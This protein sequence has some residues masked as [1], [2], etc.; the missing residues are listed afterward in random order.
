MDPTLFTVCCRTEK[1][2]QCCQT[3]PQYGKQ[4]NF[5]GL[6]KFFQSH[7][8][9]IVKD[10]FSSWALTDLSWIMRDLAWKKYYSWQD[11]KTAT[12]PARPFWDFSDQLKWHMLKDTR[13]KSKE[14]TEGELQVTNGLRER[15]LQLVRNH[16]RNTFDFR[17]KYRLTHQC[18]KEKTSDQG[19]SQFPQAI[20]TF[21]DSAY[22]Q[23]KNNSLCFVCNGAFIVYFFKF[24][25]INIWFL[26]QELGFM[27][28]KNRLKDYL[29]LDLSLPATGGRPPPQGT[30]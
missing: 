29:I 24:I 1:T 30:C 3:I 15:R 23:E 12:V 8:W 22:P 17:R 16:K 4:Q 14:N 19:P 20:W 26:R 13:L 21:L 9:F 7:C 10:R 11:W 5:D 2:Q 27:S 6:H 28:A 18:G 25:A